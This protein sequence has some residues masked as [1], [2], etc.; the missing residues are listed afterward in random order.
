M[1]DTATF[2][3]NQGRV[4]P[5]N[6]LARAEQLQSLRQGNSLD[7]ERI[8]AENDLRTALAGGN[9]NEI[10]AL[11]PAVA[12]QRFDVDQAQQLQAANRMLALADR[13]VSSANPKAMF[14]VLRNSPDFVKSA[15]QLGFDFSQ[16]GDLADTDPETLRREASS[17]RDALST[18]ITG[19]P[20]GIIGN[21]NIPGDVRSALAFQGGD[22]AFRDAFLTS[23]RA[24]QIEDIR[25]VPTDITGS[26]AGTPLSTLPGEVSA[27]EQLAG[28]TQRGR[29]EAITAEVSERGKAER[30][31]A[32]TNAAPAAFRSVE[33][34]VQELDRFT[35]QVKLIR[36]HPGLPTATGFGGEQLSGI[37][38]TDA[39]DAAALVETLKSQSFVSALGAM[40]AAS[41]T[42]GAVGNVS[43]AEGAKFEN[44]FVSLL[45]SQSFEQ[46]QKELDRLIGINETSV[47]RIKSAY[48]NEFQDIPTAPRFETGGDKDQLP[49]FLN[50]SIE[51]LQ[52]LAGQT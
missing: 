15:E 48:S 43:D 40:R 36:D 29:E 35:D 34:A 38:G 8:G 25:G 30:I 20:L 32:L 33:F 45:R 10:A 24:R 3:Q 18:F 6:V 27:A 19:S 46:F 22:D 39:A 50:L 52:R 13:V 28:G 12:G 21:T 49:D 11:D 44:A 31:V 26:G 17:I 42:G 47:T 41:K 14:E 1:V 23:K 9:I 7:R 2:I 51:E 4:N 37:P 5:I 16:I